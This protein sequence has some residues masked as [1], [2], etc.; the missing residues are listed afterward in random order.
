MRSPAGVLRR[1]LLACIALAVSGCGTSP[2]V[3]YFTLAS[4][5]PSQTARGAEATMS[6]YAIS[7][8][9]VTVPELVDR[10]HLVLRTSAT[11]VQV[12]EQARWAASLK[13][14]IPRVIA[15][16]LARLL[17]GASTGTSSQRAVSAPDYRVLVDIQRF[18]S[19]PG[20]SAEIEASWTVRA[21]DGA[22]L[23]GRSVAAE[24]SR[25]GYDELVAAHSRALGA[26]SRDIANAIVKLRAGHTPG[27]EPK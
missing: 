19:T 27:A 10:P 18:D 17:T 1:A 7:V 16:Q 13:S 11:Q 12:A 9:P 5:P 2:P 3:R 21:R 8:G 6:T 23:V 20:V 26:V 22:L 4:E 15:D 14:E 24:P 25:P